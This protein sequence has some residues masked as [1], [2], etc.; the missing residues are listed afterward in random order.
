MNRKS[1]SV[2]LTLLILATLLLPLAVAR[3]SAPNAPSAPK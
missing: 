1:V 2:V 3:K